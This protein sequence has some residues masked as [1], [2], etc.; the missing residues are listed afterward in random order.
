MLTQESIERIENRAGSHSDSAGRTIKIQ[1]AA[2]VAGHIDDEAAS[3]RLPILRG[4]AATSNHR[5]AMV[6]G[7]LQRCG[8]I[9]FMLRENDALWND[10]I[11]R[12]V[13]GVAPTREIVELNFALDCI[14]QQG[15]K[16]QI[17]GW[18]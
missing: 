1:N 5:N 3:D 6:G 7:N 18:Q 9:S 2:E 10:L 16:G 11:D 12:S 13:G 4:A 14:F 17:A 15:L 8:E